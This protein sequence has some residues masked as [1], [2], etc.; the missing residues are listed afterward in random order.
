MP[1]SLKKEYWDI[2]FPMYLNQIL[3]PRE[4]PVFKLDVNSEIQGA[5]A[6]R[7]LGDW[8]Q[9]WNSFG[10]AHQCHC[11]SA[12]RLGDLV[13]GSSE[14]EGHRIPPAPAPTP[15]TPG[16]V[17]QGQ[18]DCPKG[19]WASKRQAAGPWDRSGGRSLRLPRCPASDIWFSVQ[20]TRTNRIL[21]SCYFHPMM[22]FTMSF[23]SHVL[24]STASYS[25]NN[26]F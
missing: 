23:S 10:P 20:P 8:C 6:E 11:W 19:H 5:F 3:T 1:D 4:T 24:I 21:F 9:H 12:W 13:R 18:G 22:M 26:T 17:S 16:R 2:N 25:S 14:A 15:S 7:G